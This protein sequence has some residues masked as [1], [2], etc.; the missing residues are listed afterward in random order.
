MENRGHGPSLGLVRWQKQLAVRAIGPGIRLQDTIL[1]DVSP[2]IGNLGAGEGPTMDAR[3]PVTGRTWHGL[4][5]GAP[6]ALDVFGI[7]GGC[8]AAVRAGTDVLAQLH[9]LCRTQMVLFI[10]QAGKGGQI[11][12]WS[13]RS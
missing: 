11:R 5:P 13:A 8:R 10:H 2:D 4:A 12:G 6:L 7:Q 1:G 9:R 3:H